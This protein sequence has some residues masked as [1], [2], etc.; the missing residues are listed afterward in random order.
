MEN[1]LDSPYL[2][3]IGLCSRQTQIEENHWYSLWDIP[4][5]SE[6][7]WTRSVYI[8]HRQSQMNMGPEPLVRCTTLQEAKQKKLGLEYLNLIN[9][10]A[11]VN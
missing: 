7:K 3:G 2:C 9:H 10:G 5:K 4:S 8:K 11:A 1:G 6:G